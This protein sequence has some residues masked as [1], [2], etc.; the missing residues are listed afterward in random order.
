MIKVCKFCKGE[1]E[2]INSNKLY[3][4][5][6]CKSRMSHSTESRMAITVTCPDCSSDRSSMVLKS[7]IKPGCE[8]KLCKRCCANRAAIKNRTLSKEK[9]HQWKGGRRLDTMGYVKVHFPG[10]A[11]AD[12]TN[13]VR[14]HLL[15]A[16]DAYGED[17][18]RENGGA[19]HHIDGNKTNN[20]ITNLRLVTQSENMLNVVNKQNGKKTGSIAKRS[21][22]NSSGTIGV[23][24]DR[25]N[26][27]WLAYGTLPC[28]KSTQKKFNP[29][30]LFP[31]IDE[32]V[33]S[34]LTFELAVKFRKEL[35]ENLKLENVTPSS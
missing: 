18:V 21:S 29:R 33:A 32:S 14:E 9:S 31:N 3:C 20:N 30:T 2:T 4:S 11:F 22:R 23:C 8:A 5:S 28:G 13:Y 1:F 24:F 35:E 34:Q 19:V 6:G 15:V 26:N 27:A 17:F 7:K 16:A 25:S 12:S 10:H